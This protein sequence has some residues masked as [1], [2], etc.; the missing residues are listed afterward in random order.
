ML[1]TSCAK[2]K[3]SPETRELD[4][5]SVTLDLHACQCMM[6]YKL[7]CQPLGSA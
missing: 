1:V 6:Q 5:D 4:N 2:Y 3:I 7:E